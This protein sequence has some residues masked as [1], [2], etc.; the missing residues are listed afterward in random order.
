[1]SNFLTRALGAAEI[2]GK[3]VK[4]ILRPLLL[5]LAF[6]YR[7]NAKRLVLFRRR[8]QHPPEHFVFP[9]LVCVCHEKAYR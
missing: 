5:R 7:P 4:D 9:L 3:T 6:S 8:V 2:W 1:M